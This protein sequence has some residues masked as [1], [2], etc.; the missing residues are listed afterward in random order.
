MRN[1]KM[2]INIKLSMTK[3]YNAPLKQCG[4]FRKGQS[5]VKP[6]LDTICSHNILFFKNSQKQMWKTFVLCSS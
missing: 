6:C 4:L 2:D 5:R 3:L 1:G